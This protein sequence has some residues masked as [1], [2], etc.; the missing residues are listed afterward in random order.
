MATQL[1]PRLYRA[2]TIRVHSLRCV[3]VAVDLT[4]GVSVRKNIILEG[5]S[6]KEEQNGKRSKAMH[7]LVVLLGGKNLIIHADG[8]ENPRGILG[9][10]YLDCVL[11]GSVP[12]PDALQ[13]PYGLS[14]PMLEVGLFHRWLETVDYDV[15]AVK[16]L[17]NG[18][19]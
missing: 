7:C 8:S 9:R 3:E 13:V 18:G 11:K 19:R 10:V 1:P 15:D 5:L 16:T 2:K 17:L 12:C 14:D 6:G 4:M